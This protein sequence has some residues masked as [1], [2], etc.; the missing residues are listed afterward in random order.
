MTTTAKYVIRVPEV[1]LSTTCSSP[2][3]PYMQLNGYLCR[4]CTDALKGDLAAI[5]WLLEDLEVTITR[6]DR[7]SDPSGRSG[8][9]HPLPIRINA[10]EARRD[11]NATLAAWAMHIAGRLDGLDRD[12]IWTELRLANY[13]LDHVGTILT[14]PAAGQIADEIGNAKGLA[15][16]TIDKPQPRVFVGPCEDCDKDLYAHP[17]AAEVACKT[18]ECGAIYPIEAR[19][20]WLLGKAEDQ[21]RTATELSRALPELLQRPLTASQIRAWAFQG[22][23]AKHPPLPNRPNDPVYRVGDIIDLCSEEAERQRRKR[24]LAC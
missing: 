17:R 4:N 11:L 8:D 13:L 1:V 21:L 19:R 24:P 10:M 9:E 6:Q 15:M 5:P 2:N 16:R 22:R 7:L 12:T 14:D 20:R 23:L 3:C 18:P